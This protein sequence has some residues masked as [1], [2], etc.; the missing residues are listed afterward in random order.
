MKI[1]LLCGSIRTG[2]YNKKAMLSALDLIKEHYK[3]DK[4]AVEIIDLK[5]YDLPLYNGDLEKAQGLPEKAKKLYNLFLESDG[6]LIASPE[7]NSSFTPLLKNSLDWIS[8]KDL[9]CINHKVFALI[10]ASPSDMGGI[11]G[12]LQLRVVLANMGGLVIPEMLA[13][14]KADKLLSESET[15]R[16][17]PYC[18]LLKEL[19]ISFLDTTKRLY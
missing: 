2:S 14:P 18:K 4:E 19:I 1:S 13:I 16:V 15:W 17:S 10:A 7:Y 9:K 8:R 5:D 6:I 3:E 12:L 11:R